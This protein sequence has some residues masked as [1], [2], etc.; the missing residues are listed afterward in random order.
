MVLGCVS[1]GGLLDEQTVQ[2]N[3]GEHAGDGFSGASI[4]VRIRH[5]AQGISEFRI[6]G[7]L[8]ALRIAAVS[9]GASITLRARSRP[10]W[11][12]PTFTAGSAKEAASMIPLDELPTIASTW[13]KQAPVSH[14]VEIDEDVRLRSRARQSLACVR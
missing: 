9:A 8:I 12:M 7:L 14:G 6:E 1:S 3:G 4:A 13:P 11:R 5:A 2:R 10:C